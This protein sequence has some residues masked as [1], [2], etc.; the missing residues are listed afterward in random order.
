MTPEE[1]ARVNI[2][3]ML[4]QAGW[5]VQD[6][7][8]LNLYAGDGVAVREFPLKPGHGTADYLLYVKGKAA[9]VV[10]AKPK[11]VT[12]AGVELQSAKYGAGLPD[13]LPAHRRPLPFLYESTGEETQF[14]NRLDRNR[15]ADGCFRST[16]RNPLR[17]GSTFPTRSLPPPRASQ[18]IAPTTQSLPTFARG[19]RPYHPWTLLAYGRSRNVPSGIWKS[20]WPRAGRERWCRW[21]PAVA[22]LLWPAT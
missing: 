20:L 9:G 21:P 17:T 8:D 1:Q 19:Y 14:T 4:E 10:E 2:D 12:L 7:A 13:D 22:R 6:R 16:L 3:E 18:K 5:A 11:G 15:A